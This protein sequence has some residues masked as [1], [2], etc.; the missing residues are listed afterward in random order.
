MASTPILTGWAEGV[1]VSSPAAV[2]R[3]IPLLFK[4]K[5]RRNSSAPVLRRRR[6]RPCG[7]RSPAAGLQ[8][9]RLIHSGYREALHRAGALFAAL[10]QDLGIVEV[11]R[12]AN[13]GARA[14]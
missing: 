12:G 9:L 7:E 3:V 2:L 6:V 4:K 13:D 14:N 11:R 1:G 10:R 5:A 8:H